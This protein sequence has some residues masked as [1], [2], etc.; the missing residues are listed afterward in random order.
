M[1]RKVI[2][3]LEDPYAPPEQGYYYVAALLG[4]AIV[5]SICLR[6][7]RTAL[8]PPT[9][10][11]VTHH[12]PSASA[13]QYFFRCFR[14]GM[15][16]RSAVITSVYAKSL[17]LSAGARAR[18]GHPRATRPSRPHRQGWAG[19]RAARSRTSCPWTL[20]DCKTSPATST[21]CAHG[22]RGPSPRRCSRT[23]AHR[24]F[25]QDRSKLLWPCTSWPARYAAA[26]RD[27]H[28]T[29]IRP[30]RTPCHRQVGLAAAGGVGVILL[31]IPLSGWISRIM[32]SMQERLMR[33]KDRRAK[34][35]NEVLAGMKVRRWRCRATTR[36][37]A[38]ADRLAARASAWDA[39]RAHRSSSCRVCAVRR[40]ALS[41]A[42]T[43]LPPSRACAQRGSC[44]LLRA[45]GA[46]VHRSWLASKS[47]SWWM[48][49]TAPSRRACTQVH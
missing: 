21:L 34:I 45:S 49:V 44:R 4:A 26:F 28:C 17:R 32:S 31:L 39:V 9:P 13:R 24:R 23:C 12:C 41:H 38:R 42:R 15:H 35:M 43:H 48:C 20:S 1:L 36:A 16:L 37:R 14:T 33:V 7:V 40:S 3:F 18:C 30:Y 6:Q 5:Q 46:F 10:L 19:I 25:G 2:H 27:T 47:S 29:R 8:L 11:S 22:S